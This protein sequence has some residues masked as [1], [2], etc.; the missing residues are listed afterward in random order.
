MSEFTYTRDSYHKY[1]FKIKCLS[2]ACDGTFYGRIITI[3]TPKWANVQSIVNRW[4][5]GGNN[6]RYIDGI[7]LPLYQYS[8]MK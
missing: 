2:V 5:I 6:H 4:N 1:E 3:F 8:L 7:K